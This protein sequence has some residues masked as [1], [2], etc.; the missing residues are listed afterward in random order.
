MPP[1]SRGNF[2]AFGEGDLERGQY[3]E[4][5]KNHRKDARVPARIDQT[6]TWSPNPNRPT[7]EGWAFDGH[8]GDGSFW[9]DAPQ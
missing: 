7:F 4:G 9:I 2:I 5:D 3:Y 1:D 6:Q 8:D